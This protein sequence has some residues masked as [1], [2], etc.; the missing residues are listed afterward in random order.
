MRTLGHSNFLS[1]QTSLTEEQLDSEAGPEVD[2]A[3]AD[4]ERE[5]KAESCNG[6]SGAMALFSVMVNS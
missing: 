6:D 1:G 3:S 4:S 5:E 2:D